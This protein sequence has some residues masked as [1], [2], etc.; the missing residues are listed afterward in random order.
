MFCWHAIILTLI[1]SLS[2]FLL[3]ILSSTH[4]LLWGLM[5]LHLFMFPN[6]WL[7]ISWYLKWWFELMIRFFVSYIWCGHVLFEWVDS[8]LFL[9]LGPW[10]VMTCSIRSDWLKMFVYQIWVWWTVCLDD[11][12]IRHFLLDVLKCLLNFVIRWWCDG[13]TPR[14]KRTG[15]CDD[16]CKCFI[17]NFSYLL[18]TEF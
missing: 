18:R 14:R 15:K 3:F 10:A 6:W 5:T 4:T 17:I 16:G 7:V 13:N 8:P 2:L 9:F 12:L 1:D 11:L